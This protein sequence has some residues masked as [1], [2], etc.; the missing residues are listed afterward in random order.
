MLTIKETGR[1]RARNPAQAGSYLF[2]VVA[3]DSVAPYDFAGIDDHPVTAVLEGQLAAVVCSIEGAR[4]RPE[5]R[6]LVA[7]QGVLKQL[8]ARTTPLPLAF[9]TLAESPSAIRRFLRRNQRAFVE[10]LERLG[11]KVEMGVRVTWDVP[12]IFE[13]F[14]NTHAVLREAR[15]R[16]L[17]GNRQPSHEE[18]IELGRLFDRLLG[19]DRASYTDDVVRQLASVCSELKANP[20]RDERELINLACLVPRDGLK[21]FEDAVFQAARM[22]DNNFAFDYNGPWA[23]HNFVEAD[24]AP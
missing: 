14:V 8:V 2:A 1:K 9:G 10:E 22:F 15:D 6:H 12:N 4:I 18:K 16:V 17:G 5:R 23:P 20:C 3:A 21:Q 24:L 19:E 11:G 7:H 13:Y